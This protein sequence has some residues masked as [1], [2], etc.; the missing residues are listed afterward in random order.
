MLSR[1]THTAAYDRFLVKL[2]QARLE[3]GL[4]QKQVATSLGKP[5]SFVS[6]I[7][8]GER[9]LD[10]VEAGMLAG[11]YGKSLEYFHSQI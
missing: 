3:A 1:E 10:I 7:E 4:T 8:A 9:R 5:Q 11:L 2:R 6:K